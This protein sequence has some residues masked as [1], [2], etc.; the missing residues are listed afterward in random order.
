MMPCGV[1]SRSLDRCQRL[2]RQPIVQP[3]ARHDADALRLDENLPF[4][5][6]RRADLVA[7]M[8]VGAQEPLAIPAMLADGRVHLRG[9]LR[10][11]VAARRPGRARARDCRHF[12][13]GDHEQPGDED[14]LG[15]FA[16]PVGRR[17]ERF[18]RFIREG[19]QVEAVVPVGAPDQRQPVRPEPIQRV[20]H[21]ALQD[22][23]R[24]AFRCRAGCRKARAR[25]GCPS[26]RFP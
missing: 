2:R 11:S 15:D 3:D 1:A 26:R 24:A 9:G 10:R 14:R 7:E 23:R 22:A 20:L 25:R 16:V 17:L 5:A 21:A 12:L 4:C 19:V 18:A 8:V 6:R 13:R